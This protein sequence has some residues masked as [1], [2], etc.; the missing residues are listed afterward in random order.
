MKVFLLELSMMV[1]AAFALATASPMAA[2]AAAEGDEDQTLVSMQEEETDGNQ[3]N[4]LDYNNDEYT[5]KL[6]QKVSLRSNLRL[7]S[8]AHCLKITKN[9]AFEFWHFSPFLVLLKL[10][11]LVTLFDRKLQCF[12][13]SQN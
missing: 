11:C 4:S 12:K 1:S 2:M 9:V 3:V 5:R 6:Y 8:S 10:T 13:N 7:A